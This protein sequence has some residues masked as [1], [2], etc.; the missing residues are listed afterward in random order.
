MSVNPT[1]E[2]SRPIPYPKAVSKPFWD[3][4]RD[5]RLLVQQCQECQKYVFIPQD[6]CRYCLSTDLV[7][8]ESWGVGVVVTYTV[9]WRPQTPAFEVPYVIAVV[10][11]DEGYEMMTNIIDCPIDEIHTGMK[12]EVSFLPVRDDVKLP[13]FTKYDGG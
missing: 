10:E 11:L 2:A 8:T 5:E 7:W 3:A 4:A 9:V 1:S 12:V 13:C 6:F